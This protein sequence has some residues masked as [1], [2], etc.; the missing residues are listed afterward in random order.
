MPALTE[1]Q[2][3]QLGR[4][5]LRRA[6]AQGADTCAAL[7]RYICALEARNGQLETQLIAIGPRLDGEPVHWYMSTDPGTPES[8]HKPILVRVP[9][10]GD[11]R[12]GGA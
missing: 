12:K 1:D 3:A 9:W 2:Q 11:W 4:H 8:A 7:E 5:H 6:A 10:S